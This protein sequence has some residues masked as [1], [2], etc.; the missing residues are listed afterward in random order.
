MSL[1][2]DKNCAL[3]VYESLGGDARLERG[4]SANDQQGSA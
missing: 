1:F 2:G 4:G 3:P